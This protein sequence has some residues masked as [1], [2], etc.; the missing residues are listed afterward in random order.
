MKTS[1]ARP[2]STVSWT[3]VVFEQGASNNVHREVTGVLKINRRLKQA[4]LKFFLPLALYPWGVP[5]L[6]LFPNL[7]GLD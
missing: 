1:Q 5:S 4:S 7:G 3:T 6:H 2:S